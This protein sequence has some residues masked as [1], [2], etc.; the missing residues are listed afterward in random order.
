MPRPYVII[1]AATTLDGKIA[2][3][4]HDSVISTP[5]DKQRVHQLR[6]TV[7]AIMVGINTV[8]IDNPHLTVKYAEGPSPIRVIVD[9][10]A[11]TPPTAR[12]ITYRPE[13]PTIIAVTQQAP[14]ERIQALRSAGADVWVCGFGPRVDLRQLLTRLYTDRG[15]RKL[16]V[17]GGGTL[18]WGLLSEGLVDE[19]FIA[20]APVIVGGRTAITLAEGDGVDRIG[21]GAIFEYIDVRILHRMLLVRCRIKHP[22]DPTRT[23]NWFDLP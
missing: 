22:A 1:S 2:T 9:S 5:E 21:S 3:R 7:D 4:T 20:I 13:I 19:L 23:A 15:V 14:R 6:T 17:E 16:M 18:I 10:K 8:L 12:V 11:R